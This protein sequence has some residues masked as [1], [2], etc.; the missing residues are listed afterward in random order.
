M[1]VDEQNV[2]ILLESYQKT[3]SKL[4]AMNRLLEHYHQNYY[5]TRRELITN[6]LRL[7]DAE[8]MIDDLLKQG[9]EKPPDIRLDED[10]DV[11]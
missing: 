9:N 6:R 8:S 4:N 1:T 10:S 2:K 11:R 3:L 5:A 7:R